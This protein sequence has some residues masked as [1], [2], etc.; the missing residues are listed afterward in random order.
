VVA[1]GSCIHAL[2]DDETESALTFTV[3]H[4]QRLSQRQLLAD[5]V[6]LHYRRN[7]GNFIRGAFRVRD[8]TIEV[9]PSHLEDR[10]WRVTLF[11]DEI[12]GICEF[13]PLT[14]HKTA[15]LD[16]IK[17]YANSHYVTPKPTLEQAARRIKEDLRIRLDEFNAAGRLLEAQRPEQRV[18]FDAEMMMATGS[19]A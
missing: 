13:D 7:D 1:S 10:A 18:L 12:E 8:D 5:L 15:E 16:Q 3:R 19:G 4:G 14:G 11:G 6:A 17:L 9:F 2:G